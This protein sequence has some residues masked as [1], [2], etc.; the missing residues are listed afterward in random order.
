LFSPDPIGK[1]AGFLK[2]NKKPLCGEA[3]RLIAS[4]G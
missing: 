1:V 3:R 2:R 4:V